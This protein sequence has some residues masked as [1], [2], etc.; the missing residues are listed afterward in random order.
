MWIIYWL[1]RKSETKVS[2]IKP[3]PPKSVSEIRSNR[4]I[5]KSTPL[6]KRHTLKT[7]VQ[8]TELK[9]IYFKSRRKSNDYNTKYIVPYT[10]CQYPFTLQPSYWELHRLSR[11]S[12]PQKDFLGL[13]GCPRNFFVQA[14]P[15]CGPA[16]T[17]LK[18]CAIG[19][20]TKAP[21]RFG[22]PTFLLWEEKL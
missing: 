18:A 21:P 15:L 5:K 12:R 8:R 22:D 4:K 3:P 17:I 16:L 6:H 11:L 7:T 19:E 13:R 2:A 1:Q 10:N 14:G 9:R 20:E